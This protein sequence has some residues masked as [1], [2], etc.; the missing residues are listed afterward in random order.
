MNYRL[1]YALGFKPWEAL[2]GHPP[3]ADTLEELVARDEDGQGPPFGRALDIGTGS[4]VWGV[5]LAERGWDVT[6]VD[7]VEKALNR[8]RDRIREAGVEMRVVQGDVTALREADIGSGFRLLLDTGTFHGLPDAEREAMG[9]E[10]DAVAGP[11]ATLILDC[12]APR[13]RG[14]LPRG[15]SQT[16]VEHAFPGWEITDVEVAD[17]EP[18][19]IA[20]LFKFDERFYRLRRKQNAKPS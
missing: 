6:G 7:I 3:F 10:V 1:A 12:F 9:R 13:R 15:A 11:D 8:A 16:D 2:A 14:P 19:A 17:T 18:D 4:A 5:R 20:R